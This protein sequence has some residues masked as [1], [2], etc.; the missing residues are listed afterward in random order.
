MQKS[1]QSNWLPAKRWKMRKHAR[2]LGSLFILLAGMALTA[3]GQ[4]LLT[5]QNA[6]TLFSTTTDTSNFRYTPIN[7]SKMNNAYNANKALRQPSSN[8]FPKISLG[9]WPPN[10]PS[11]FTLPKKQNAVFPNV[12]KGKNPF[13]L[14]PKQ[15]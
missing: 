3:E 14:S 6:R 9:S 15:K 1:A 12:F 8:V 10:T 13:D 7:L 4:Q 2:G 11:M 5:P